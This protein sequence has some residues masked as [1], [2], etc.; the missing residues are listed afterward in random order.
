MEANAEN[1]KRDF[2]GVGWK[3]DKAGEA[4]FHEFFKKSSYQAKLKVLINWS[5]KIV[6]C[7]KLAKKN[8]RSSFHDGKIL[9]WKYVWLVTWSAVMWKM[10]HNCQQQGIEYMIFLSRMV[11]QK[12]PL[13]KVKYGF[14]SKLAGIARRLPNMC[15]TDA[16]SGFT[17]YECATFGASFCQNFSDSTTSYGSY[18]GAVQMRRFTWGKLGIDTPKVHHWIWCHHSAPWYSQSSLINKL[19]QNL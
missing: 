2:G 12:L 6:G 7:L 5:K 8:L 15:S 10:F 19:W 17:A 14:F 3:S 4:F 18:S 1:R 13:K 11:Y 9:P 16:T